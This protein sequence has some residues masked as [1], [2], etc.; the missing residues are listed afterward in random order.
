VDPAGLTDSADPEAP[1]EPAD[2]ADSDV[3]EEPADPEDPEAP[4]ESGESDDGSKAAGLILRIVR[5]AEGEI[6]VEGLPSGPI[7][8]S[9]TGAGDQPRELRF[10]IAGFVQTACWVDGT[11]IAPRDGEYVVRAADYPLSRHFITCMGISDGVPYG[12][13]IPFIVTE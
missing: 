4:E 11:E 12:R 8:L 13:E 9:Q 5:P 10:R 6:S 2:P 7:R 1:K 3:P